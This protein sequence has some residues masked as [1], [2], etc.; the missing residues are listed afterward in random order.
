MPPKPKVKR[1]RPATKPSSALVVY[2]K[3]SY[4]VHG[5]RVIGANTFLDTK[6]LEPIDAAAGKVTSETTF[7]TG[8]PVV[9]VELEHTKENTKLSS[10]QKSLDGAR[11]GKYI[12]SQIEK[13]VKKFKQTRAL[14]S[15]QK[16]KGICVH[17]VARAMFESLQRMSLK[18]VS[19]EVGVCSVRRGVATEVD[20]VCRH[21]K[22]GRYVMVELKTGY[23]DA[24]QY[25]APKYRLRF[26]RKV[27]VSEQ[28]RHLLQLF[29]T[30]ILFN[31][32]HRD[33]IVGDSILLQAPNHTSTTAYTLPEWILKLRPTLE[34]L[35][36]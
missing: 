27:L 23:R 30:T 26:N 7:Q 32:T 3:G 6:V 1:P 25:S 24:R 15:T 35:L 28:Q 2:R 14:S 13:L 34:K 12:H 21:T 9:H 16:R 33:K 22:T 4:W 11:K 19:S 20:L 5:K 17:P 8:S 31:L 10:Y 18:V 36:N 29:V